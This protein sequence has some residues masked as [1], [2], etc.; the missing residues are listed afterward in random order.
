[1]SL[2]RSRS[3]VR[4]PP[5]IL[6]YFLHQLARPISHLPRTH[7]TKQT[8][9]ST[10]CATPA[11]AQKVTSPAGHCITSPL[12]FFFSTSF[13]SISFRVHGPQAPSTQTSSLLTTPRWF[14]CTRCR[15]VRRPSQRTVVARLE[16]CTA[17]LDR[18]LLQRLL[19]RILRIGDQIRRSRTFSTLSRSS[20][21]ASLYRPRLASS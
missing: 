3:R 15:P 13:C 18:G 8:T 10:M 9:H 20:K 12:G 2:T 1:M 11:K 4:S 16:C 6:L 21:R 19:L 7:A 5:L 17:C 14:K